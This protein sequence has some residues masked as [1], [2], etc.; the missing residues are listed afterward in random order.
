[1]SNVVDVTWIYVFQD[2][3]GM[4]ALLGIIEQRLKA[5]KKQSWHAASVTNICVGLLTGFKVLFN[6]L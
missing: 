5:G 3:S 1:M 6:L 4:L 2:S